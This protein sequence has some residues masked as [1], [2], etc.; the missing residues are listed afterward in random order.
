MA[1]RTSRGA[2]GAI[3]TVGVVIVLLAV[4]TR[5]ARAQPTA[6]KEMKSVANGGVAGLNPD[7]TRVS[8][9]ARED[10]TGNRCA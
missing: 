10:V 9:V 3:I 5:Q 8:V 6:P 2:A 7:T 1:N 4:L